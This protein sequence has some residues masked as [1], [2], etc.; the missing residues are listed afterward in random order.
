M[1]CVYSSVS[2]SDLKS[3]ADVIPLQDCAMVRHE[4]A[5]NASH[6]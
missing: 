5:T 3:W 6:A 1:I 4:G 2:F